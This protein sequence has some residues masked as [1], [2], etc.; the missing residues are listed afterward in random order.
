MKIYVVTSGSYSDY[1]INSMFSSRELAQGYIDLYKSGSF[2]D[3]E[4]YDLD[5]G[6]ISSLIK[7]GRKAFTVEMYKNGEVREVDKF[8]IYQRSDKMSMTAPEYR[9]W[10]TEEPDGG[11]IVFDCFAKDKEHAIKICNEV[12]LML[13]ANNSWGVGTYKEFPEDEITKD[14]QNLYDQL[15]QYHIWQSEIK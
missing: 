13:I 1:G 2:N 9:F 3:I 5:D 4:E 14:Y 12:R 6:S 7:S 8:H 15:K 11:V 10:W